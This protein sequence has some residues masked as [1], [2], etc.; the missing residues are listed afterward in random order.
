VPAAFAV[1]AAA[2]ACSALVA[3]LISRSG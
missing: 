2:A 1:G 3:L